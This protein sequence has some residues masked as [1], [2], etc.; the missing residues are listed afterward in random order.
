MCKA[1]SSL[2][3]LKT[4]LRLG[5]LINASASFKLKVAKLSLV[6]LYGLLIG[7]WEPDDSLDEVLF[8][9]IGDF[10]IYFVRDVDALVLAATIVFMRLSVRPLNLKYE[11]FILIV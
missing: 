5:P 9:E 8:L 10:F 6:G 1:L 2:R 4:T 11:A 3:F 7:D